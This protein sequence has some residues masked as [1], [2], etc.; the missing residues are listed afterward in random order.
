MAAT[1]CPTAR[2]VRGSR[3]PRRSRARQSRLSLQARG[4][5]R[6]RRSPKL[7]IVGLAP[8]MHGANRTGRPFTG[9]YAGI[10]FMSRCTRSGF[11]SA[12]NVRGS[13]RRAQLHGVRIT[14]AVKCLPPE[15]KPLPAEIKTCNQY[16]AGGACEAAFGHHR[17]WR[18]A[19]WRTTRC[20]SPSG[21][22]RAAAKFG[23]GNEHDLPGEPPHDRFLPLQPLQHADA[24]ADHRDVPDRAQTSRDARRFIIARRERARRPFRS[25]GIHPQSAAPAGRVPHVFAPD[26]AEIR[27]AVRRQGAQPARSRRQLLPREQCRSQGAGAGRPHRAHRSHGHQFR[28]RGAAAR[29]QPHQGAQAA[30]QHRAARRQEL[31]VHLSTVGP[32]ISAAGVLPRR[33]QPA[34]TLLRAV[35]ERRRGEGNAAERAEDLPHPELPRHLL[36]EPQPP[37]PATPDRPLLGALREADLA[38]GLRARH[39]APPSRCS[40]A[41]TTR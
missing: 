33:A 17:S 31:P 38:R 18:S 1:F 41:A 4:A 5:F 28:D 6:R 9:D 35:P 14:N 13:Q 11:A 8:G 20:S 29:V 24:P 16:L 25:Q 7:L 15:N 19:R 32:R 37:L 23:H 34:G 22:K 27:A 12:P 39:R 26:E 2:C 21:L 10:L 40:R 3:L 36:R 30:L